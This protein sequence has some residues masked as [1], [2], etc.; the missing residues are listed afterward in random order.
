M[1]Y[2]KDSSWHYFSILSSIINFITFFIYWYRCIKIETSVSRIRLFQTLEIGHYKIRSL[3]AIWPSKG[4]LQKNFWSESFWI[5]LIQILEL[6]FWE[7]LSP[8]KTRGIHI[9]W[10]WLLPITN[11]IEPLA[12]STPQEIFQYTLINREKVQQLDSI[13]YNFEYDFTTAIFERRKRMRSRV[14]F[15][16]MLDFKSQMRSEFQVFFENDHM[17]KFYYFSCTSST[18]T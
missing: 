7:I 10:H 17:P 16:Q 15:H 9:G 5:Q 3:Q 4:I 6:F 11:R 13:E 12:V 8:L 1:A 2:D 14:L 18:A